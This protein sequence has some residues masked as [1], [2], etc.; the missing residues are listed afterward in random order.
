MELLEVPWTMNPLV[1]TV[2][3]G[4]YGVRAHAG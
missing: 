2:V 1:G 4:V 3:Y